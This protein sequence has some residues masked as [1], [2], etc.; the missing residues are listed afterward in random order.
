MKI[1]SDLQIISKGSKR[2]AIA[3]ILTNPCFH[4]VVL[5][6]ISSFFYHIHLSPIA[7]F[8]WYFNRLLYSVDI[9]YRADIAGGFALIHGLG[10]VIGHD[11]KSKGKLIVYQQVTIGGNQGRTLDIGEGVIISQPFFEDD[12]KVYSGAS[13]YGPVYLKSGTVVKARSVITEKWNFK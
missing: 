2:K 8:F 5:F 1:K 10:T 3:T 11:V 9:D 13:I 6:R 12:V 4:S 7:K